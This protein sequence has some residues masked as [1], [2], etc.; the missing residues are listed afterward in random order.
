MTEKQYE[1]SADEITQKYELALNKV[2]GRLKLT[3]ILIQR[4]KELRHAGLKQKGTFNTIMEP[5]LDEIVSG[6]LTWEEPK[7][8][9]K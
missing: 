4:L 2:G 6:N 3:S 5:L 7:K 9:K 1:S 8:Q